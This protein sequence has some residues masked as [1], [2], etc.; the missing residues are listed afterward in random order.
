MPPYL[1]HIVILLP[2][3][4][5]L[6]LPA[7][8]PKNFTVTPGGTHSDLKTENKLVCF[9]DGSYIE[10]ISFVNDDP[11][12]REE[13][14]WGERQFGII[15]F[16]FT[17]LETSAEKNWEE[18]NER[19]EN[20]AGARVRYD[21]PVEGGRKTP[22]GHNLKWKVTCP[23]TGG[24]GS[25]KGELPFFCHDVTPRSLRVPFTEESTK[26]PTFGYG[27][28]QMSIYVPEERVPI[29]AEAYGAVLDTK[30]IADKDLGQNLG[31][32]EIPRMKAVEGAENT[33]SF[34]V[35]APPEKWQ[36]EGMKERGGVMLSDIVVGGLSI[37]GGHGMLMRIDVPIEEGVGRIFLDLDMPPDWSQPSK[38][39]WEA[40]KEEREKVEAEKKEKG[41]KNSELRL[42]EGQMVFMDP[43]GKYLYT[44]PTEE[45]PEER[46]FP[47]EMASAIAA[48]QVSYEEG[49]MGWQA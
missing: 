47:I 24:E 3:A 29:L 35:Q 34:V 13:H 9:E 37:L 40:S 49:Q 11:A 25:Q 10:F 14:R 19:L 16:A 4:K 8:I 48:G 30:N 20:I 12:N 15:D 39:E 36:D 26:H 44:Q 1:D 27:I 21:K 32:F 31:V 41:E 22:D 33:I 42:K 2:H 46:R 23:Q 28:K 43:R 45:H 7:W 18:L 38:E 5:L 6:S 17:H